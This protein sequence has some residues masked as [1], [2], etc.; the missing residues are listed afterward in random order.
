[1]NTKQT[2]FSKFSNAIFLAISIFFISFI[3]INYNIRNINNAFISSIIISLSFCLLIL[4]AKYILNKKN[5]SK[6]QDKLD[7]DHLKLQLLYGNDFDTIK[8]LCKIYNID[9]FTTISNN[10]I[11]D[12]N[13]NQDYYFLFETE[14]P[15]IKEITSAIK[16]KNSNNITLFCVNN[17]VYHDLKDIKITIESSD[18]IFKKLKEKNTTINYNLQNE[19]NRKRSLKEIFCTVLNKQKSKNYFW[20]GLMLIF[21]SFFTPFNIYYIVV[22]TILLLLSIYVRFNKKFN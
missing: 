13:N 14:T 18:K 10:H 2:K 11:F 21:S 12:Y 17:F 20:F 16:N 8:T 19:K 6:N 5:I 1:M 15:D 4:L 7:I 22:G 9:N 3:W